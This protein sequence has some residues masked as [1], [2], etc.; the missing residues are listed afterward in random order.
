MSHN[1]A[2]VRVIYN[3][4]LLLNHKWRIYADIPRLKLLFSYSPKCL[5]SGRSGLV[6]PTLGQDGVV[7]TVCFRVLAP[8][9]DNEELSGANTKKPRE[10]MDDEATNRKLKIEITVTFVPLEPCTKAQH[11]RLG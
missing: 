6:H 1:V 4:W 8:F 2:T 11:I 7:L 10:I 5:I 9:L 3:E